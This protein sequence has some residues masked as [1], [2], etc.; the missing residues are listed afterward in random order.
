MSDDK[1]AHAIE[2]LRGRDPAA[3]RKAR[4]D[5]FAAELGYQEAS[6]AIGA[7]GKTHYRT[8]ERAMADAL[9]PHSIEWTRYGQ[10]SEQADGGG[11][12]NH[13]DWC[14]SAHIAGEVWPSPNGGRYNMHMRVHI[15]FSLSPRDPDEF[16]R[17]VW[18]LKAM[19]DAASDGGL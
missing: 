16:W 14:T 13:A 18:L 2:A 4:A 3:Y 11:D 12:V 6:K 7:L 15:P 19:S 10:P 5:Y 17:G 1:T 9:K 8:L